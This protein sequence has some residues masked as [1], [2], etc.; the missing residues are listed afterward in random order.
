MHFFL[1]SSINI[2]LNLSVFFLRLYDKCMQLRNLH[3]LAIPLNQISQGHECLIKN[4]MI[5]N[6]SKAGARDI[7]DQSIIFYHFF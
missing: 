6:Y 5:S 2:S 7:F 1:S 3:E 4:S